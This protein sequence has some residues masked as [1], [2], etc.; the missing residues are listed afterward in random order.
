MFELGIK[1]NPQG[2]IVYLWEK[3]E[4]LKNIPLEQNQKELLK[5]TYDSGSEFLYK[6]WINNSW[7]WL[8]F[9]G[10]K[11]NISWEQQEAIR[12][13]G[14]SFISEIKKHQIEILYIQSLYGE[15]KLA[16]EFVQGVLLRSYRFLKYKSNAKD[17]QSTLKK[18]YFSNN[19]ASPS[20]VKEL[21][22]VLKAVFKARDLVNEPYSYLSA[23]QLSQEI[24]SIGK[25][26][27][28]KVS[29]FGKA[30]IAQLK[31]GGILAVNQ[32][33]TKEPTFNI[34]E[35]NPIK[36]KNK[37]PI[38]LVGKGV[39]FDTGGLS[40]KPTLNSMDRMKS[41]MSGAAIVIA[42]MKAIAE[43]KLKTHV[44][45]LIPATD[46]MPGPDAIVPGDIIEMYGGKTVEVLNTDAEGRLILADALSY[47]QKY[48]PSL[49]IDFATLTGAASVAVGDAGMVNMGTDNQAIEDFKA[50]GYRQNEKIVTF[51]LWKEYTELLQSEIADLKNVGGPKGG[52]ITAGAFLKEFTDYPWVH[53]DIA[54]VSHTTST[55]DYRVEGGTG[56]GLRML[57]DYFINK[58]S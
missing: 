44:V 23:E 26:A 12:K 46:N 5:K 55:K 57:M 31:M 56:Y 1:K 10:D 37:N 17:L 40:L 52:A 4:D 51:P 15:E 48:K 2:S 45:A 25:D 39:V 53:F 29:T 11:E 24:K 50:S 9:I 18:V 41:D 22:I 42:A 6:V 8:A 21:E 49:V 58:Y 35:Y 28:F 14:A 16:K 20:Q 27:G 33:S 32:G 47:A 30:K 34:L 54:G 3:W 38:V 19:T 43:L 13:M 7:S 36:A